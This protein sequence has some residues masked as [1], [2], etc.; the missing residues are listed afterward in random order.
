ML[1]KKI[2][3]LLIC[4]L[5]STSVFARKDQAEELKIKNTGRAEVPG[6]AREGVYYGQIEYKPAASRKKKKQKQRAVLEI[7]ERSTGKVIAT[8]T[9]DASGNF[10]FENIRIRKGLELGWSAPQ[11]VGEPI[12]ED[13]CYQLLPFDYTTL[14]PIEECDDA[15]LVLR[16]GLSNCTIPPC[17]WDKESKDVKD[18]R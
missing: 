9:A 5:V 7:R 18:T 15:E 6:K 14:E 2:F 12:G 16:T 10:K 3:T 4:V 11:Q 1:F 17:P 13:G 8:T